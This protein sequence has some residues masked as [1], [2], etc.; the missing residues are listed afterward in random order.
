MTVRKETRGASTRWIIDILYRTPD[1]RRHRFR[2]DAQVQT[3]TGAHAEERRLHAELV[4]KGRLD[5]EPAITRITKKAEP[6]D[7]VPPAKPKGPLFS[8]AVAHFRRTRAL[9]NLKPSTR[10]GYEQLLLRVVEPRFADLELTA[11]TFDAVATMDAEL[12]TDGLKPS[13]RR[14]AHVVVRSVLRAAI[15]LGLLV[16]MPRLPKL[17]KVGKK[18]LRPLTRA[19]VD[20]I[21]AA[22]RPAPRLAFALAAFAGLRA[23][24]VR[25]LEWRDVDLVEETIIV[26]RSICRKITATPKSGH[27]RVVPIAAPLR[28][29]LD[30]AATKP[31]QPTTT[32]APSS[33][34]GVWCDFALNGAFGRAAK[35]VG[36]TGFRFH[37][38]RHFFVTQLFRGGAPAP[39][40][41]ALAGHADLATTQRYAHM[42]ESDLRAAIA[43]LTSGNSVETEAKAAE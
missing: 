14:N 8:E 31:H 43:R 25:G 4:D 34:G 1:G 10:V 37:D 41:Q 17:P 33:R 12:A 27:E 38:L 3:S 19:Q 7:D 26:R 36:L 11:I 2:R 42:I 30:A 15:D 35:R 5:L 6:E 32:V 29:Y 16:D 21:L 9:T 18:V 28:V 24:E 23:G 40:V 22:T 20:R 39:A 13:S